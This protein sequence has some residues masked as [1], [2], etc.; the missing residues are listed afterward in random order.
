MP[1]PIIHRDYETRSELDLKKVG[2]HAYAEHPSTRIMV[3]VWIIEHAKDDLSEPII[4]LGD[5][6]NYAASPAMPHTVAALIKNG[7]TVVGHNA[8]FEDA[9][10]TYHATPRL[11]WVKPQL[12]NLDCTMARAAVQALPLDLDRLCAALRVTVRKDSAGRA[13]MLKMCKPR[14]AVKGEDRSVV[15]WNYTP[16]S[17]QR[18]ARYCVTDVQAEIEVEHALRPLQD[19]ERPIW[20]LDQVMNNRGVEIDLDFVRTARALVQRAMLRVNARLREV[21]GGAVDKVTQVERLK[22][23]A[24][25]HGVEFKPIIKTRRNGEQYVTDAA[26]KEAI[27]DLLEMEEDEDEEFFGD[28]DALTGIP[29]KSNIDWKVGDPP[30]V[31][32]AFELRLEAGKSSLKKLDKFVWQA[33]HGRARGNLQYHAAGPGRWGGRGIQLQNLVRK[34]ISEPGGWD[35]AYRD[36][37]EL[38]DEDFESVWGSVFDVV[39]RMMR[40]ALIAK[41]G[42]KLYFADYS[43]VEARGC[44]WS[45]KQEDMVRLFA[46]GGLIY[47]EMA[48][49]IFGLTVEEVLH[50]HT[51]KIDIIPRFVGKETIL[52]CGYGMGPPAFQRNCKKKG[53]IILPIEI[54]EQGVGGWRERNPRVMQLWYDLGDAARNAIESEGTVFQAGPFAYRKVG[55][56]LQC[57]LPSGRL[58][59]YRRP[60]FRPTDADFEE[61][62]DGQGVPRRLWKLHYWGVNSMT[63]QWQMETTWGGKLLENCV[64]GMCRDFLAGAMLRLEAEG[65]DPVLSVHDEA[66][67]ETPIDFGSVENFVDI[68]TRL[69][70]WAQGFPLRAEGGEGFR[71]AKG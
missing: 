65:Y 5:M 24:R 59:W 9:I 26:D 21:T 40:G 68:M 56:W 45:A 20:R 32:A 4:W 58:L 49:S 70:A 1:Y 13:L 7:A 66:I 37:R 35:Q 42:Y 44:V 28:D 14:S 29:G 57:R 23:F 25:A 64:Q 60:N 6:E 31:R 8:A 55:K 33:P 10:D 34:G 67:A 69:P 50:L 71:Y 11:W 48:A 53:R 61:Y 17:H 54:C 41:P 12:E 30:S 18:L 19:Q 16:A 62:D 47:E 63:K 39:A 52:G 2:A 3:A 22:E 15:H 51:T 38:S 43:N 27:L 36:M 46:E